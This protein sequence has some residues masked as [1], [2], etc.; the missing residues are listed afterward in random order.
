V[1]TEHTVYAVVVDGNPL[2]IW[3]VWINPKCAD[4]TAKEIR[5]DLTKLPA[6]KYRMTR[7]VPGKL[8]LSQP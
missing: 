4:I 8:I 5:D 2:D 3:S 6:P 7:V 1:K